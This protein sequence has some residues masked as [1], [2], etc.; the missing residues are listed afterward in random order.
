MPATTAGGLPY[1]LPT[2][3]AKDGAVAIKNL[4]DALQ[5]RG[6]A[7]RSVGASG[8]FT[9]NAAGQG[10]IPFSPAFSGV[11]GCIAMNGDATASVRIEIINTVT[12][13]F[14]F[15]VRNSTTDVAIPNATVRINYVA[16]GAA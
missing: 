5:A 14:N 4:A 11:P 7:Q 1:P 3:Q 8:V 13:G 6:G 16:I 15:Q 9:A 10:S 2:E 12:T